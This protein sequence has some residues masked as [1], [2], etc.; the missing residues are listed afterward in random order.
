MALQPTKLAPGE[1]RSVVSELAPSMSEE[2]FETLRL[3]VTELVTNAVRHASMGAE[4]SI[5]MTIQLSPKAIRVEVTD[6]GPG[7]D[8]VLPEWDVLAEGQRG[9]LLVSELSQRWG[10][11]QRGDRN[12]VWC[13]L[14]Q[15]PSI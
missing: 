2:T 15:T 4:A 11:T 13:E 3:V 10:V 6:S 14:A 5:D 1:A 8:P 9:L 7:F 12:V